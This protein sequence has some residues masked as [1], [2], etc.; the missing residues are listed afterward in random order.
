MRAFRIHPEYTPA[1]KHYAHWVDDGVA[2][3][4][5][6]QHLVGPVAARWPSELN[7]A[8]ALDGNDCDI[9]FNPDGLI[10]S[11]HVKEII[12]PICNQD[13]EWLPVQVSPRGTM[14]LLHPIKSVP[15]GAKAR[16]RQ[17]R[18]GDN[19]VEIHEYDFDSPET[20]PSCFLIPQP[21]TSAAGKA[22][23]SVRGTFVTQPMYLALS[24]FRGIDF[25]CIFTSNNP[26][27]GSQEHR[28]NAV[29]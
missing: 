7:F 17:H 6:P 25:A 21:P 27:N 16:F 5:T 20:L 29:G 22:G 26:T 1:G 3:M 28:S 8:L 10:Y 2:L 18:P 9:L 23:Y 13:A 4:E 12:D 14:Y 15:L 24:E 19:I 11:E